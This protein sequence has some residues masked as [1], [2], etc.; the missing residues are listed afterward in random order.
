MQG[1]NYLVVGGS[2][3]IGLQIV[4]DL[5]SNGANIYALSRTKHPEFD[6]LNV[7]YQQGDVTQSDLKLEGMPKELHGLIYC[8]GSIQLK[9]FHRITEA[10]FTQAFQVNV[11]G[12]FRVL[13]A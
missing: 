5:H 7:Q 1:K 10:E 4:K 12:A 11:L 6:S 9:P 2:S 3:G 13:Q 8:P